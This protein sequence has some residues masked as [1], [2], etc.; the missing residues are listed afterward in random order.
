MGDIVLEFSCQSTPGLQQ[1]LLGILL[2]ARWQGPIRFY[3]LMFRW[4]CN[5]WEFSPLF[6]KEN[7][8]RNASRTRL[9]FWRTSRCVKFCRGRKSKQFH[10]VKAW[11][12]KILFAKFCALKGCTKKDWEPWSSSKTC[13]KFGEIY[14]KQNLVHFGSAQRLA[15]SVLKKKSRTQD[16]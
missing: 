13:T 5:Y 14:L 7:L 6:K 15:S 3:T 9:V 11:W 4:P 2:L 12:K 1:L 10:H 8:R 16:D